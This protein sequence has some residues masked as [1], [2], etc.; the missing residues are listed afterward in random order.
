YWREAEP[1]CDSLDRLI[2]DL[3]RKPDHERLAPAPEAIDLA[4]LKRL[5][6]DPAITATLGS[7][8][9]LRRFWETCQLP[10][11][12]QQ[13]PDVHARFVARLWDDLRKGHIGADFV[14]ARIAELAR[15]GGDIDTLPGPLGGRRGRPYCCPPPA[16]V[17]ARTEGDIDTLQGRIAG[18]RSWTYICQRPDWV[19]ARDEMAA[20]ARGAE[21]RLSDALHQRLTER[22]VNRRTALLMRGMGKDSDL[23]RVTL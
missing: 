16:A 13:G 7:P 21:A 2:A 9:L 18:I 19:L 1:R 5:A 3:E 6:E 22:F 14:A 4:V 17:L 12:R 15:T 23:L 8:G 20:R 11:F 10:D